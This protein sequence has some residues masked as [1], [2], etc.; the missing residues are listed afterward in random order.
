MLDIV[1]AAKLAN[2]YEFIENLDN[3][4]DT[5]VGERGVRLSGGQKQSNLILTYFL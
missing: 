3:K 2:A 4:F 5:I 1:E